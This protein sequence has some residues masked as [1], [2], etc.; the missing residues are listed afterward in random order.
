MSDVRAAFNTVRTAIH[1][2]AMQIRAGA[3]EE[4]IAF[5]LEALNQA[6]AA[7]KRVPMTDQLIADASSRPDLFYQHAI[8]AEA[9]EDGV[10]F[11]EAHHNIKGEQT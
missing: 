1:I 10:R 7:T 11:A 8:Y 2:A 5:A 4:M 6:E 3:R 9:F